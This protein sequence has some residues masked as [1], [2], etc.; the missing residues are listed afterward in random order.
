MKKSLSLAFTKTLARHVVTFCAFFSL[1][2][3]NPGVCQQPTFLKSSNAESSDFFGSSVASSGLTLVVGATGED[4]N[5]KKVN[6]DETD[7][8]KMNSGAAYVFVQDQFGEWSQQAYL[9]VF[10][11]GQ[12]TLGDFLSRWHQR[13]GLRI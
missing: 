6:G 2:W 10:N 11:S 5:A 12:F 13:G 1:L 7:N 3:G 8:S 9:K 4:S